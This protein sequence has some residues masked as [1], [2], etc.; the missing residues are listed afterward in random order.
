MTDSVA[1]GEVL[2]Y[3][4][5]A[6]L[7]FTASAACGREI[8]AICELSTKNIVGRSSSGL[9]QISNLDGIDIKCGVASRG[10]FKAGDPPRQGLR[11]STTAYLV[12]P[13]GQLKL[14]P[15]EANA[16]GGEGDG[17]RE[18]A[19][20]YVHIP[21][22]QAERDAEARRCQ[23]TLE[24][25]LREKSMIREPFTSDAREQQVDK[26]RKLISQHRTGHFQLQCRVL[27]GKRVLGTGSVELE[28][29]D[30]GR[31]CDRFSRGDEPSR[32]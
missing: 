23:S 9:P 15:S 17:D 27:D 16:S 2:R 5:L 25:S 6:Q 10:P 1:E 29:I 13:D 21:L 11:A 14:V 18:W 12:S 32:P 24:D 22:E 30:K 7:V 3:I 20:F 4:L 28:V 26:F 31:F 19:H 8:P